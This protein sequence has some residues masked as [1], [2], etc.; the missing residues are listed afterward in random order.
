MNLKNV[1]LRKIK[2]FVNK[3]VNYESKV[4][5]RS[6]SLKFD[7][8]FIIDQQRGHERSSRN[9]EAHKIKSNSVQE[10]KLKLDKRNPDINTLNKRNESQDIPEKTPCE[11]ENKCL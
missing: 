3:W 4:D 10:V 11:T 6:Q 8:N 2:V 1:L 7:Q 5:P 9:I